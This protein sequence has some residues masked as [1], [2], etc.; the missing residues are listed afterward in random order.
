[1][2]QKSLN[3]MRKIALN[4]AKD[5]K[6]KTDRKIPIS[7]VLRRNLFDISNL[8]DFLEFFSQNLN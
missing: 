3:I 5:F 1:M 7:G 6:S 2:L 8:S 4:L